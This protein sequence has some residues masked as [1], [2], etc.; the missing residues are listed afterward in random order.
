MATAIDSSSTEINV[1]I[2]GET[3]T[4]KSTLINYLTN[5]FHDGSLAN[6]K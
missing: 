6:L 2:I 4:G 5:L 1:V 3:G